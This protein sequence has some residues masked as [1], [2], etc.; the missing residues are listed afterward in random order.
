MLHSN[1]T[2][3]APLDCL[4]GLYLRGFE[5]SIELKTLALLLPTLNLRTIIERV[6]EVNPNASFATF[7]C[8]HPS[9]EQEVKLLLKVPKKKLVLEVHVGPCL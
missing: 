4:V 5:I 7:Y 6:L 3:D 8:L 2:T 1:C 9:E